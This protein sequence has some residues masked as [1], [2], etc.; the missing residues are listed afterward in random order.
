MKDENVKL[1]KND[2]WS[3]KWKDQKITK[4][5][6]IVITNT[7]FSDIHNVLKKHLPS[8]GGN[9]CIEIGCYPGGFMRYFS[10]EFGYKVSGLEYIE[11]CGI[12]AAELL[13]DAGID[14]TLYNGDIFKWNPEKQWDIVCSFGLV[15]HFKDINS[16]VDK[17]MS[18]VK[19]DGW[20]VLE[21]PNHA[22]L[23]GKVMKLVN[24]VNYSIHNQMSMEYALNIVRQNKEFKV[25]DASYRGHIGFL[26]SG[27]YPWLRKKGKLWYF[28]IG[29]AAIFLEKL[30]KYLPNTRML[31]PY[32]LIVAKKLQSNDS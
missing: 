18:L 7:P 14:A 30:F 19:P 32:S 24:K 15:E 17:H 4:L 21:F 29:G 12:H 22:G 31:S 9:E 26:N 6:R 20:L 13:K 11:W 28:I 10:E 1:S 23:Y 16:V 25:Y 8:E 3:G 27:L 5:D 2:D